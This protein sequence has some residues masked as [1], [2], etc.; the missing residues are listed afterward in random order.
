[1]FI[2]TYMCELVA[3]FVRYLLILSLLYLFIYYYFYNQFEIL[4]NNDIDI[5]G[6]IFM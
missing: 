2:G 4:R 1:M 6:Y 3:I 5:I